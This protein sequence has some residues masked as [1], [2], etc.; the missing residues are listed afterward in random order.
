MPL[1]TYLQ[2]GGGGSYGGGYPPST[3]FNSANLGYVRGGIATDPTADVTQNLLNP[4]WGPAVY[5]TEKLGAEL[6]VGGGYSGSPLAAYQTGR[7]R[8]ADI[9]RR[10]QTANS[11]LS[12]AYGR[13]PQPVDQLSLR[14]Q[15]IGHDEFTQ[16]LAEEKRQ[17]DEQQAFRRPTASRGYSPLPQY[18]N[19]SYTLLP[20]GPAQ[21]GPTGLSQ[22]FKY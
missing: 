8:A 2:S 10:A 15:D 20:W 17:F 4:N 18:M 11:L 14:G 7:M 9:E 6:A 12:G 19:D 21:N 13:I 1:P 16:R 5:D 22:R 3:D